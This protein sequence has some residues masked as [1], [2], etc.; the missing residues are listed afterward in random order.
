MAGILLKHVISGAEVGAVAAYAAN[1]TQV[2]S[3]G[4]DSLSVALVNFSKTTNAA[5][6]E[7]A[8]DRVNRRLVGGSNSSAAG[9]TLYVFDTDLGS[10][11][12]NC[13]GGCATTWPPVLVT[14]DEG[15]NI[16]GLSGRWRQAGGI[17]RTTTLFLRQ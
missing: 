13:N 5:N 17:P 9:M 8:Y 14:D 1:G 3:A 2:D 15:A 16:S 10:A 12:S 11:G 6:D 7:V 4:G